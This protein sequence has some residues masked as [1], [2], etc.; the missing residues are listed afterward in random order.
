MDLLAPPSSYALE[1][2]VKENCLTKSSHV[3]F[4]N[5]LPL[6]EIYSIAIG[7]VYSYIF[8]FLYQFVMKSKPC[9]THSI[10]L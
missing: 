3:N 2:S 9:D 5:S 10:H 1:L 6:R 4:G 8:S 7:I